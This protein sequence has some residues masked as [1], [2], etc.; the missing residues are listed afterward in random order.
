MMYFCVINVDKSVY[1]E[2]YAA[3]GRNYILNNFLPFYCLA[4]DRYL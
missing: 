4:I 2:A 3:V 1:K